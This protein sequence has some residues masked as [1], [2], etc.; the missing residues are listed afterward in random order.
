V[1]KAFAV[2]LAGTAALL[3][4]GTMAG[5]GQAAPGP[6]TT[7]SAAT[8]GGGSSPAPAEARD[9][10]L[11]IAS[12]GTAVAAWTWLGNNKVSQFAVSNANQI[13]SGPFAAPGTGNSNADNHV[14][15]VSP[16]GNA[17]VAWSDSDASGRND[18]R[19]FVRRG[20]VVGQTATLTPAWD[21]SNS[22][23]HIRAAISDTGRA[24]VVWQLDNSDGSF[25]VEAAV[26]EAGQAFG[27]ARVISTSGVN[28]YAPSVGIDSAGNAVALWA[29]ASNP[30]SLQDATAAPG[31]GFGAPVVVDSSLT[32]ASG[33]TQNPSLSVSPDGRMAAGYADNSQ[34]NCSQVDTIEAVVGTTTGGFSTP[35]AVS[36][37]NGENASEPVAAAN[38][39]GGAVVVWTDALPSGANAIVAAFG[40]GGQFSPSITVTSALTVGYDYEYQVGLD[41][42]K[43][44][45]AYVAFING[46]QSQ[47][48]VY[49]ATGSA[50]GFSVGSALS[51]SGWD[52]TEPQLAVAP[53]SNAYAVAWQQTNGTSQVIGATGYSRQPTTLTFAVA[54]GSGSL[55]W[56]G[57]G[58]A[59]ERVKFTLHPPHGVTIVTNATTGPAGGYTDNV[60]GSRYHRRYNGV[61]KVSGA[62][63]GD[64]FYLPTAT[65][66][67]SFSC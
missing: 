22:V 23:E 6:V 7:I 63:A 67:F 27:P 10:G 49:L 12:N 56:A 48:A 1:K 47:T 60:F 17:V 2:G 52:S 35:T 41:A 43:T 46:P 64:A 5:T 28:S 3:T 9:P 53:R 38:E 20:G 62:F 33:A 34:P 55:K 59:M 26:A 30:D 8:Y 36:N 16:V 39:N 32:G 18:V 65:R 58:V 61:C 14:V 24:V 4:T 13:W 54:R 40:T 37:C 50:G 45:H 21:P 44:P 66:T 42:N 31:A 29:A 25:E 19:A 57:G 15:S 11:G 51:P